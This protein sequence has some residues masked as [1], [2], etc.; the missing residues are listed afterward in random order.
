MNAFITAFDAVLPLFLIILVGILVSRAKIATEDWVEILNRFA[1]WIGFPALVITLLARTDL[2]GGHYNRMIVVNSAYFV[3]CTLLA[4]PYSRL[5][6]FSRLRRRTFFLIL[7]YGNIT[8][9]GIPVLQSVMGE[10]GLHSGAILSSV[11]VFWLLTLGLFLVETGDEKPFH[12]GEL[13]LKLLTN[14]LLLSVIAGLFLS[15]TGFKLP[16][17]FNRSLSIL[18]PSVTPI[19]L[20]S[21]GIFMGFQKIGPLREWGHVFLFSL[22]IMLLLP[23]IFCL[24]AKYTGWLGGLELKASILEAAMPV[25]LTSYALVQQYR[26]DTAF[27]ARVVLLSTTLSL[28]LIP[29]WIVLLG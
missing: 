23:G 3:F 9:L 7:A 2:S 19:V 17:I 21:L 11:Y 16:E 14:P 22:V 26:L 25:G 13:G 6:R 8:Y 5:F 12:P 27:T 18:A 20:F 1:L 15:V 24:V 29:L 4:F 10:E 28:I